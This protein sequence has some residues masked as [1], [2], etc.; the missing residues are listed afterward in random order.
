MNKKTFLVTAIIGFLFVG[1]V[2]FGLY[3]WKENAPSIR[4]IAIPVNGL[5][6]ELCESWE[7]AFQKALSDEAILQEIV[8][9]TE[10]AEKLGVPPEEAVSHLKKA[11]KVEFVKRKNWIQIGLWGK[12]RQNEDLE[13]IAELLHE[14]AVENIVK[15]E[16]SFQQYLDAIKK[17]QAA[18][19]SR[20]P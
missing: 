1:G 8:D 15:I 6:I 11:I 3:T 7:S 19:K 4:A 10:Y 18:A 16:P 14:T 9:E 5:P 13:K 2:G 12:K 17:Q 20:Q